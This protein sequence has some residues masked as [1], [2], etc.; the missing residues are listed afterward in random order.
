MKNSLAVVTVQLNTGGQNIVSWTEF[1][2]SGIH[3][4][5]TALLVP[6]QLHSCL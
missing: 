1:Q 2:I 4:F 3:G 5:F 6:M